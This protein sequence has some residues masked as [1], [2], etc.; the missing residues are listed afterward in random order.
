LVLNR[1]FFSK[2]PSSCI[3][4]TLAFKRIVS[5]LGSRAYFGRENWTLTISFSLISTVLILL[6]VLWELYKE[7]K[8]RKV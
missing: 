1:L 3:S 6:Q 7:G 8:K 4:K 2:Q 5:D